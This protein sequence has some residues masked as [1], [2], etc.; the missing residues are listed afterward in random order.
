ALGALLEQANANGR[1]LH[2]RVDTLDQLGALP[3]T[4]RGIDCGSFGP[5]EADGVR[6]LTRLESLSVSELDGGAIAALGALPSLRRVS[7]GGDALDAVKLRALARLPGLRALELRPRSNEI[8]PQPLPLA[9]ADLEELRSIESLQLH[10][11]VDAA[12]LR[13][14]ARLPRL[15]ELWLAVPEA[16]ADLA[17][18]LRSLPALRRLVLVGGSKDRLAGGELVRALAATR[19]E[20]LRLSRMSIDAESL[21]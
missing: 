5:A 20:Q 14:L 2:A 6:R 3:A 8:T 11:I 9:P 1:L 19:V 12:Q 21:Q 18:G 10:W 15:Q 7:L 16:G 17:A 13:A 4:Q